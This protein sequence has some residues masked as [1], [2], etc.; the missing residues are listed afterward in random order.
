MTTELRMYGNPIEVFYAEI[1]LARHRAGSTMLERRDI[2]WSALERQR[3]ATPFPLVTPDRGDEVRAVAA[4]E[5]I[6]LLN[7]TEDVLVFKVAMN[8]L[9]KLMQGSSYQPMYPGQPYTPE[10]LAI[11]LAQE[12]DAA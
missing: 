9:L 11:L 3:L 5:L 7:A 6:G 10:N 2:P 1:S 8:A 12:Q 4:N